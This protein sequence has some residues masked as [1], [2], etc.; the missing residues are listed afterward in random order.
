MND[1]QKVAITTGSW[2]R[3]VIVIALA[4]AF[5]L[6]GKFVLV[7]IASIVIASALEPVTLWAK[8]RNVPRLPTV[9]FFY[10]M[11]AVLLAGFFYF[12]LLP[13]I[14]EVSSFIKTMT[15]YS[16]SVVNGSVLSGMFETQNIF[17]GFDTP[18]LI[19]ELNNYLN[20]FSSFLSQ[21]V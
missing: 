5:F 4:Y 16:N 11:A 18:V 2:V 1:K 21:G 17:G 3:G 20:A 13:L 14:G 9:I 10:A 19:G 7:L 8:R 15:V 12:L 6:V